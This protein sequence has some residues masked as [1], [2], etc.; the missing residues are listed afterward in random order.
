[1]LH[2][3]QRFTEIKFTT[4]LV[5]PSSGQDM[6]TI[7]NILKIENIKQTLNVPLKSGN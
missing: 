6:Q 7:K 5:R 3:E 1:M 4:A 2:W